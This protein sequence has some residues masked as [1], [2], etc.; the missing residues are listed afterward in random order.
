M[1]ASIPWTAAWLEM[2]GALWD[3]HR[4]CTQD[5][6]AEIKTGDKTLAA[7][8]RRTAFDQPF[9]ED[10]VYTLQVERGPEL[11]TGS[12]HT[13]NSA[14]SADRP[15]MVPRGR[16]RSQARSLRL[17]PKA[18]ASPLQP[19]AAG[20]C[21]EQRQGNDGVEHAGVVNPDS[22][23]P[24]TQPDEEELAVS[25]TEPFN[26][27]HVPQRVV[28]EVEVAEPHA[29]ATIVPTQEVG[30]QTDAEEAPEHWNLIISGPSIFSSPPAAQ[31]DTIDISIAGVATVFVR[32]EEQ[33]RVQDTEWLG[34]PDVLRDWEQVVL[35]ELQPGDAF[36]YPQQ[37]GMLLATCSRINP[38]HD[39][40]HGGGNSSSVSTCTSL[41][42]LG[43]GSGGNGK[44]RSV[45]AHAPE[46]RY[47]ESLNALKGV[48]LPYTIVQVK[49]M[50]RFDP[51]L[52]KRVLNCTP[53]ELPGLLDQAASKLNMSKQDGNQDLAQEKRNRFIRARTPRPPSKSDA[54]SSSTGA[55]SHGTGGRW[56]S[57]QTNK[58]SSD[59][60]GVEKELNFSLVDEWT[61]PVRSEHMEADGIYLAENFK[62]AQVL[63]QEHQYHS[64]STAVVIPSPMAITDAPHAGGDRL[65]ASSGSYQRL[66]VATLWHGS[67]T[68]AAD[69]DCEA[70]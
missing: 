8:R 70:D 56:R 42:L 59:T 54:P 37:L 48:S 20:H 63:A 16:S 6:C 5:D 14:S 32:M 69:P 36:G 38:Q 18:R 55:A 29:E 67:V 43:G 1:A 27:E 45:S 26:P 3:Y 28:A 46:K 62:E 50:L 7:A 9:Y 40:L 61:V 24:P 15:D 22:H 13:G 57:K 31:R 64:Y 51:R 23:T 65:W 47:Q 2:P 34:N 35:G 21:A 10:G 60:N 58:P 33:S 4:A 68:E 25:P 12:R 44:G 66:V 53:R 41:T 17:A 30:V 49:A 19:A 52:Q 39:F 11:S